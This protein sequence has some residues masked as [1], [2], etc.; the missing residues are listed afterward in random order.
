MVCGSREN[1]PDSLELV[2]SQHPDGSV[3]AP[4]VVS[5]KHQGYTGLLHGGMTNTLLD[6]AMTHCLFMQ[7]IKALTAELTVRFVAPIRVGQTLTI[8]AQL[9]GQRRGIYQLEAWLLSGLHIARQCITGEQRLARA[10]AK[11][12]IPPNVQ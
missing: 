9:L 8:C 1:N 12:I 2:F 6:A 11:F 10:S 3:R 4:F 7:G 5:P